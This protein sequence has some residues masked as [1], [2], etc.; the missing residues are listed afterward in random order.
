M[1]KRKYRVEIQSRDV[2]FVDAESAD[3]ARDVAAVTGE[4][5]EGDTQLDI[6]FENEAGEWVEADEEEA[7]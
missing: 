6:S 2:Y 3:E 4:W 5:V 7:D 1:A